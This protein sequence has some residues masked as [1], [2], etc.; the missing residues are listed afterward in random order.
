MDEHAGGGG[1]SLPPGCEPAFDDDSDSDDSGKPVSRT[2]CFATGDA[3]HAPLSADD[4]SDFS[5]ADDEEEEE[6]DEEAVNAGEGKRKKEAGVVEGSDRSAGNSADSDDSGDDAHIEHFS[7]IFVVNDGGSSCGDS[8]VCR[9]ELCGAQRSDVDFGHDSD[10]P[11]GVVLLKH[12]RR[13]S[14]ESDDERSSDSSATTD[15]DDDLEEEEGEDTRSDGD[16][17]VLLKHVRALNEE[18]SSE[19]SL[20]GASQPNVEG[21][22]EEE[23]P[24]SP[25]EAEEEEEGAAEEKHAAAAG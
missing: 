21:N 25:E 20:I 10:E 15:D 7:Q 14:G 8:D 5:S 11:T 24:H 13:L 17:A 2:Y 18:E 1:D 3:G 9:S 23:R 6:E 19:P 12:S 4:V 22:R 16:G